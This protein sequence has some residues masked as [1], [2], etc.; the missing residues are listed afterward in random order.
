[1]KN[2]ISKLIAIITFV[3]MVSSGRVSAKSNVFDGYKIT[4]IEKQDI[5]AGFD[6][7]WV[8]SYDK[9]ESPIVISLQQTKK[10]K[11]Y[12]VR[13]S[14]FEVAYVSSDKGFGARPVKMSER[15]MPD[16]LTNQVINPDE[17][18]RQRIISDHNVDEKEALDLIA[19]YLP[20]LLNSRF[21]HLLTD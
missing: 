3:L 19:G 12:L 17:L 4:P 15:T 7:G 2:R 11:T 6:N 18:S 20:D 21:Q 1:M 8:L 9:G 5:K 13:T 16:E 10:S 14:H